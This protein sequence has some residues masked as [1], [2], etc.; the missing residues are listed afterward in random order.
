MLNT[1]RQ[2]FALY[3]TR[4]YGKGMLIVRKAA[5]STQLALSAIMQPVVTSVNVCKMAF[6]VQIT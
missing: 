3:G 4:R 1:S 5:K 6:A 2:F